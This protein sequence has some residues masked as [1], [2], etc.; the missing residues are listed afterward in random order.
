MKISI[1]TATFNSASTILNCID[2]VNRQS[3][4]DIEHLIIDGASRDET[5]AIINSV[6]N[7]VKQI[8]SEPDKG[9]YDAMNKGIA[10]AT[11]EI[12]AILNSDDLYIDGTV[13]EKIMGIFEMTGT[14]C[15]YGDLYYVNKE[16]TDRIS[17]HWKTLEFKP[18]AFYKGWHPAHPSFFLRK[19]VYNTYG[20]FDLSFNLAADFEFMLRMLERHHISSVYYPFPLVRMRL[21]GK[22]NVSLKNIYLQNIECIKAFEKNGLKVSKLY[23][24]YRLVPKIRQYFAR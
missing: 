8:I 21:G 22:T 6:P 3:Y 14:D 24:L 13:I 12:V 1:I 18:G 2:S 7:R 17:R 19:N 20:N 16:N 11:G 10:A 15:V 5:L 9:I 23:P 4:P